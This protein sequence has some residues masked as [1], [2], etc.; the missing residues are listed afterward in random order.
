MP[1]VDTIRNITIKGKADGVDDATAALTRLTDSIKAANEN[2][3]K[4]TSA[5]ND[6]AGGFRVTGEGALTAANHLRQAAEAAYAFSP[7]F[8]GVVNEM[9]VPVLS[10]SGTAIAALA[11]G[12]VTATNYAG[13]G[14][15][16]LA[17]A[18]EKAAPSLM[19][20]TGGVRS[21]GIAMEAF[22][23]SVGAAATSILGFLSP[24]LRMVGWFALA[25]DG[26][27]MVGEAWR[28][29]GEKLAEYVALS[30]KAAAAN[31]TTDFFQRI[32][33]A[34][35]DAK[36]PV[37][38]LTTAL[39]KLN[40]STAGKLGGSAASNG[41]KTVADY[42]NFAGNSGVGQLANAN[43]S[44]EKLRA[45]VSLFDQ[46]VAKGER[47]AAIE[48]VR[49]TLGDE[50][51][52]KAAADSGFLDKMVASADAISKDELV[53]SADVQN[54]VDLQNR[55]DAAEKILSQRWH[56]VQDLL[57]QLGIKFREAWVSIVELTASAF[58]NIAKMVDK[59][60]QLPSWFQDKMNQGATAFMNLTTTPES[61]A[62][63][64]KSF[65]ISSDPADISA[66]ADQQRLDG[67]RN[68]GLM[69]DARKR[70]AEGMNRKFDTSTGPPTTSDTGA[71]DRA[72]E[73][74]RKYT[75]TTLAAA[76]AI[77]LTTAAQERAKAIA[78]LTAAGMKDG[79]TRE[80]AAAKAEMSGL[81]DQAMRAADA[82]AR[83]QVN[84]SIKFGRNTAFLSSDD[85]A[86]AT[87]L[88]GLYPD[89]ATALNSVE[90]AGMR[91]NTAM[92]GLSTALETNLTS[93]LSDIFTGTKTVSQGF[94]D[95]GL[96]V[97][98]ALDDMLIKMLII[99]PLMQSMQG[100]FGGGALPSVGET[101]AVA[102]A[103]SGMMG[104]ISFPKFASGTD[105]APGGWSIVGEKGPELVNLN[106][107]AKVIPNG[108]SV[109]SSGGGSVSFGDI[110]ISVPEGTTPD[111]AA[112]I[113]AAVKNSMA[114]VI[115]ER[116]SYHMRSRGML[117][118]AA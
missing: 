7:A 74:L 55:L 66:L 115:D 94:K 114:Q 83:A 18:A 104:G 88:K 81:A 31:V 80:A 33:K 20:V 5:A 39:Q 60:G 29:G 86:I 79:L 84:S 37:D 28:L 51:A 21:A 16:A 38:A 93:G 102:G 68:S 9:A 64:E 4:S 95:M 44:E 116:L 110:H 43:G 32:S 108:G 45:A 77:D 42:G 10:A 41:I 112:A 57:T 87:Q 106:P 100:L 63:A 89:V 1:S 58:D 49:V 19:G 73:S 47:L 22:S 2:L 92:R 56:P 118:R 72:E 8:R 3:A 70:L 34:A 71:F 17:G 99:Q 103:S 62:A 40:D 36:L 46:A 15:I 30:E 69:A 48:A 50:I 82:L 26:V 35:E 14:L 13:T 98:K 11:T 96:A 52:K 117:N 78:Q 53:S 23:P 75:E 97:V 85:V 61:R 90:A 91:T 24:A 101:S 113:G 107:G 105:N 27:K 59:L 67:I 6:N 25:Y 111:N 54:A 109:P 12:M 76:N 65:G